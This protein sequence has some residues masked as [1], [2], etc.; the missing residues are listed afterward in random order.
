MFN[1]D[2][3]FTVRKLTQAINLLPNRYSRTTEMGLFQWQAGTDKTV[4]IEMKN[5][6]L[7]LVPTTPWGGVSPKNKSSSRN[8]RSFAIPHTSF[9]DTVLAAEVIGVRA[10]GT[11]N[12][13]ETVA[14]KVNDKLQSMKDKIDMTM[15]WRRFNALKGY[16]LD[17][18]GSIIEDYFAAFGVQKKVIPLG[19]GNASTDVRK[20]CM[21]VL[22]YL[23]DHAAG[24]LFSRAHALV[25]PE[26]FDAL[27]GHGAVKEIYLG[28][29]EAQNKLGGDL[30][31]GFTFGGITFEE[32]RA[33][34]DGMRFIDEGKGHLFPV[35]AADL[36][37]DFG[38]PADFIDTANSLALP[39]YARQQTKDFNRGFD[40]HTQSN[41]LP[42]VNRPAMLVELTL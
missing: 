8:T 14:M 40:L 24:L 15:E 22:R 32:Y 10:F 21:D 6:T 29:A 20:K 18:D 36:F 38:A 28:W 41:I 27:T 42:L 1:F 5:N 7:S 30:R 4:M 31:K 13:M 34:V 17:S 23:E 9:E 11:E 12:S 2:D 39:Y 19:L 37:S 33:N 25:S 26:L 3:A 35:G 16:V